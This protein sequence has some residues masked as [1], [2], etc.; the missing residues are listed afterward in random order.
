MNQTVQ[1]SL[2]GT[3]I[4]GQSEGNKQTTIC[5]VGLRTAGREN[6]LGEVLLYKL[7]MEGLSDK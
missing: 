1:V 3:Y 5:Q 7:S 6:N 4:L 2:H